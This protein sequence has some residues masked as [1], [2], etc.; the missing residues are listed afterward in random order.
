MQ[1]F[2]KICR[3]MAV[4]VSSG[5]IFVARGMRIGIIVALFLLLTASAVWAGSPRE[6]DFDGVSI[7]LGQAS[8]QA[9]SKLHGTF[10]LQPVAGRP[11][12]YAVQTKNK[13][14]RQLGIITFQNGQVV[15]L[16]RERG[17]FFEIGQ[18]KAM[19][20]LVN[21]LVKE[22]NTHATI[23]IEKQ[24]KNGVTQEVI[25]L[26]LQGKRILITISD[27][28]TGSGQVSFREVLE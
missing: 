25:T 14:S 5:G 2:A 23:S 27:P 1:D 19:T 4:K 8:D 18:G 7:R 22:E 21:E 12:T 15:R 13:T 16:E 9:L 10:D 17:N 6:M 26:Q 28:P 3:I 20:T 24:F 11:G